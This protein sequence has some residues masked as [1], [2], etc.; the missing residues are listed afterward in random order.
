MARKNPQ[1]DPSWNWLA[2]PAPYCDTF[3]VDVWAKPGVVRLTFA[4]YTDKEHEP[5]FRAAVVLPISDARSLGQMLEKLIKEAT[6]AE[7]KQGA[8]E[9]ADQA[10][11]SSKPS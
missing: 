8:A 3:S 5:F 2:A 11:G 6:E 7:G 10:M 9:A 4:E 1:D